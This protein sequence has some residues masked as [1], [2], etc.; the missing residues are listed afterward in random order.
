MLKVTE[1]PRVALGLLWMMAACGASPQPTEQ[2]DPSTATAPEGI[3]ESLP[4]QSGQQAQTDDSV[5]A[6]E[7]MSSSDVEAEP[8]APRGRAWL[9]REREL[10]SR[11]FRQGE[12]LAELPFNTELVLLEE[13][14]L[15]TLERAAMVDAIAV[16]VPA[17]GLKGWIGVDM[18][19]ARVLR[20][21]EVTRGELTQEIELVRNGLKSGQT[22]VG[23]LGSDILGLWGGGP[24]PEQ[25]VELHQGLQQRRH[26]LDPDDIESVC[27]LASAM[28]LSRDTSGATALRARASTLL[29]DPTARWLSDEEAALAEA[30]RGAFEEAGSDQDLAAVYIT[31]EGL[32]PGL[33]RAAQSDFDALTGEWCTGSEPWVNT[34][35]PGVGAL[36]GADDLDGVGLAH[37]VVLWQD[38]DAWKARA[39]TT[40]GAL[41]DDLLALRASLWSGL[42]PDDSD[43]PESCTT[44]GA[45]K[46]HFLAV[47]RQLDSFAEAG[48]AIARLASVDRARVFEKLL[49]AD[50]CGDPLSVAPPEEAAGEVEE[51]LAEVDLST[52]E[53]AGLATLVDR[54]RRG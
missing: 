10:H 12:L 31:V 52:D 14:D 40:E 54:L 44:L 37:H 16:A 8:G 2:A 18:E 25:M 46:R 45:P 7:G 3:Q 34:V 51:I 22:A 47:L 53:R 1:P 41:D 11:P 29:G 5:A 6:P 35:L 48:G 50:R 19:E 28:S 21:S 39:A 20:D 38:V 32:L 9:L 33:E 13:P 27:G 24:S 26:E 4:S 49:Q 30:A 42:V 43:D 23:S 36:T 17:T 15:T